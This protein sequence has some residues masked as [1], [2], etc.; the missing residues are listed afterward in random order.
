MTEFSVLK[1]PLS[2]GHIN[3]T[4]ARFCRLRAHTHGDAF[5]HI[6]KKNIVSVYR[7]DGSCV[8]GAFNHYFLKPGPRVDKSEN[9][10]L[11]VVCTA[12]SYIL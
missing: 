10:T 2:P 11:V 6:C 8:L 1:I 9:D 3:K 12:N 7:L 4:F 5:S